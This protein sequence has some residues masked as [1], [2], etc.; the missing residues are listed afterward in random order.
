MTERSIC[1]LF[2]LPCYLISLIPKSFRYVC[3]LW[4]LCINNGNVGKI[5]K[6]L[7]V[8]IYKRRPQFVPEMDFV[9]W[10]KPLSHCLIV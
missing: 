9:S 10:V 6:G 4:I 1:F 2:A 7:R 8:R 5:G 3:G